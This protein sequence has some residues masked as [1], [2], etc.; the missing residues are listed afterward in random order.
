MFLVWRKVNCCYRRKGCILCLFFLG[1]CCLKKLWVV[2]FCKLKVKESVFR[3]LIGCF[4][5]WKLCDWVC[6]W[7]VFCGIGIGNCGCS[8]WRFG[9]LVGNVGGIGVWLYF[10]LEGIFWVVWILE[11][12]D[13][14]LVWKDKCFIYLIC[15]RK[16]SWVFVNLV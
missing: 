3:C 5:L 4:F 2:C 15:W 13:C 10:L 12:C 6:I 1:V 7:Y 11:K 16:N 8:I 14:C 9:V